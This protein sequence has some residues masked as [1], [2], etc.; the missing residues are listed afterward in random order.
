M[1]GKNS[2]TYGNELDFTEGVNK[3]T[4]YGYN[5][6][7]NLIKDLNKKSTD[8][9]YNVLN[10]PCRIQFEDGNVIS[11]LYDANGVKLRTTHVI[12]NNT[13][14]TDYCGNVIYENGIPDKLLTGYGY[15]SLNDNKYH[16]FIRDHQGNNRVVVD[17]KGIVEEVNHYYPFG[18]LMA[19]SS[20]SN[21]INIMVRNWIGRMGWIGMIM[22]QDIMMR[23]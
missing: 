14:I 13:T 7:G 6:N 18:G 22:E 10:L 15:I 1:A 8:I 23:C 5:V 21:L 17:L 9:Q 2:S 20:T 11:Y 16:Y 4:E 19:N 12:E 3:R